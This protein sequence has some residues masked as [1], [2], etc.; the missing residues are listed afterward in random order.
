M[1]PLCFCKSPLLR[2]LRFEYL[3]QL[4][5]SIMQNA[6]AISFFFSFFFVVTENTAPLNASGFKKQF[7]ATNDLLAAAL[8]RLAIAGT[9]LPLLAAGDYKPQLSLRWGTPAT[10][11]SQYLMHS[12]GERAGDFE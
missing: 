8:A 12:N 4:L 11:S 3:H 7:H 2:F 6:I 9:T 10:I 5:L 1:P